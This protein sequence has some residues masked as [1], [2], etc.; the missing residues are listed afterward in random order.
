MSIVESVLTLLSIP[1][2]GIFIDQKSLLMQKTNRELKAMLVG[3]KSLSKKNKKELV[4]LAL[5]L[6]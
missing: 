4:D 6:N 5:K 2:K 1:K 3:V